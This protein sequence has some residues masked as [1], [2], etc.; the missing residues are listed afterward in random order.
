MARNR[1]L[2]ERLACLGWSPSC[3]VRP[4]EGGVLQGAFWKMHLQLR[5]R[6]A[7]RLRRDI[8]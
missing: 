5:V 4:G 7:L 1:L 8:F 2:G 6:R 3:W